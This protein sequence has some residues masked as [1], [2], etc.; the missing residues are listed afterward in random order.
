VLRGE[1]Y[2]VDFG[3]GVGRE[4][5]GTHPAVIVSND[6]LNVAPFALIVVPGVPTTPSASHRSIGVEVTA[7]ESGLPRDTTFLCYRISSVDP[8]RVKPGLVGAL[9]AA[10]MAAIDH[11]LLSLLGLNTPPPPSGRRAAPRP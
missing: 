11:I 9:P 3:P 4:P 7:A 2:E 5:S 1:V 6:T 10:R 8:S